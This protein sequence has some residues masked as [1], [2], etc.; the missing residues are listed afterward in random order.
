MNQGIS[1]R[2]SS[3]GRAGADAPRRPP[4]GRGYTLAPMITAEILSGLRAILQLFTFSW[5]SRAL[6]RLRQAWGKEGT[7][8]PWL[9]SSLFDLTRN[10]GGADVVDDKTWVD[11]ELDRLFLSADSTLTRVG[12]Q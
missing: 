6:K 10:E 1:R 7:K 12:S 11:L 9:V 5:R 4:C 3:G 2:A 8:D